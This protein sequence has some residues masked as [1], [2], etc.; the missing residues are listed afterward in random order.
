MSALISEVV[1]SLCVS[2]CGGDAAAACWP[3]EAGASAGLGTGGGG[4]SAAGV[5]TTGGGGGEREEGG[6]ASEPSA[7]LSFK[8]L[9]IVVLL[10]YMLWM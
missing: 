5:T 10:V 7:L 4:E 6:G 1:V 2:R 8:L 3:T 9:S